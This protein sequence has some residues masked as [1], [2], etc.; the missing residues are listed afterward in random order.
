MAA[1]FMLFATISRK[2]R[3]VKVMRPQMLF[4]QMMVLMTTKAGTVGILP[5]APR[6]AQVGLV[7][8]RPSL[9]LHII[10]MHRTEP[11]HKPDALKVAH[12]ASKLQT[13]AVLVRIL[14]KVFIQIAR[15]VD[16]L[17]FVECRFIL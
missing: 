6:M 5:E 14:M 12:T 4:M 13:E 2:L 8:G 1:H 17:F 11:R 9:L 15:A 7:L 10:T 16:L 3:A